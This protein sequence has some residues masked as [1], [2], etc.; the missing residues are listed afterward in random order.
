MEYYISFD[1][2]GTKLDGVLFDGT[3]RV[4]SAARSGGTNHSSGTAEAR[5][6]NIAACVDSLFAAAG[7]DIPCIEALYGHAFGEM[8]DYVDAVQRHCPCGS[9]KWCGEGSLGVLSCGEADGV[10][11]L[12]GTGSNT[13]YVRDGETVR[14]SGG[15]GYAFDDLGS[16]YDIGRAAMQYV[17]RVI[18]HG[19][20]PTPLFDEVTAHF[21]TADVAALIQAVY[22]DRAPARVLASLVPAVERA[23]AAGDAVAQYIFRQAGEALAAETVALMRVADAPAGVPVCLTG[24]VLDA[25]LPVREAFEAALSKSHPAARFARLRMAPVYGGILYHFVHNGLPV[26]AERVEY[27]SKQAQQTA[28]ATA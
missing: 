25:C 24:G 1:A 19:L 10:L 9:V 17:R 23:A 12:S 26:T 6:Q 18:D 22:A 15:W 13:F 11:V 28:V 3:G 27:I 21:G 16:G 5:L 14:T 4:L 20:E 8:Q 7:E 2:G